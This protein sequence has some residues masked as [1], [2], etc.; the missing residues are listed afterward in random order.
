[1]EV[2]LQYD[3]IIYLTA[4]EAA[5]PAANQKACYTG[6]PSGADTMALADTLIAQG[7]KV[8]RKIVEDNSG[9]MRA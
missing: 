4:E 3:R 1:M 7:A 9:I 6:L 5:K 8:D 2:E